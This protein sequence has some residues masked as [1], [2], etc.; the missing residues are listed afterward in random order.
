MGGC[1]D[2][3]M[4][5]LETKIEGLDNAGLYVHVP[6]CRSKCRYCDFYSVV[7][8][9]RADEWLQGIKQEIQL[10]RHRFQVFD[11]LYVGGGTPTLLPTSVLQ[12]LFE[13]IRTNFQFS[14]DVEITV[15]ANPDD[16]TR[17]LLTFLRELGVNRLSL[18]VQSFDDGAL[19]FLGRR[20]SASQVEQA[21]DWA[22]STGF[23]NVGVD[24]M[25]GLPDQSE[26]DWLSQLERALG[27]APEHLS[28]YQMTLEA[29]TP[30]GKLLQDGSLRTLPEEAARS[31]FLLTSQFMEDRGYLHYEISNFARGDQYRSR[32]NCK[33]WTHVPYLGLGPAAHSF[34]GRTRWW[35]VRSLDGYSRA[36][37][38]GQ[39]PKEGS[40]SLSA[41]QLRLEKLFLGFRTRDGVDLQWLDAD[42]GT[43]T[44]RHKLVEE[45]LVRIDHGRMTPTREG[46]VIA[47]SLPLWF[48]E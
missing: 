6:F 24:L 18:G 32:H 23:D 36:L 25:Y 43:E 22:R 45:G 34:C 16:V 3:E 5:S 31:L 8:L 38:Q 13:V 1:G 21:L 44:A 26:D 14:S 17:R 9:D 19:H 2:A 4:G 42:A 47:D 7:S 40:E 27:F 37:A 11:T 48:C 33:Y 41:E 28:C 39:A 10:L 30:L 46:M 20:H 15:E 29:E 12:G 35:N